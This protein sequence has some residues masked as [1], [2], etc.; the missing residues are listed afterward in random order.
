[1]EASLE[2]L[3]ED[4]DGGKTVAAYVADRDRGTTF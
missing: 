2:V 3:E 1:M 4:Q